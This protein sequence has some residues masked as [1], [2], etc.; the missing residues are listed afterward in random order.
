MGKYTKQYRCRKPQYSPHYLCIEDNY[1]S[2]ERV[3]EEKYESKY[4]FLRPIVSKVI[5][6]YLDVI[7][8][9][10]AA[11]VIGIVSVI[12]FNIED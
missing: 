5:Y 4:G 12:L 1:D 11:L 9:L 3:Y 6:Q 2:F 7:V 10:G 8:L